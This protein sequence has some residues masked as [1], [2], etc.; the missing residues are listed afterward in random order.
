MNLNVPEF[1]IGLDLGQKVDFTAI[2]VLEFRPAAPPHFLLPWDVPRPS[3]ALRHLERMALGTTYTKVVERVAGL[4][5]IPELQRRCTL[6]VDATGVGAP[7]V[8][9]LRQK[10]LDCHLMPVTIT[11]GD[12]TGRHGEQRSVPK[13]DL[14]STVE[15]MLEEGE[16]RI[17]GRLPNR[18][19]LVEELM[20]LR[21][22]KTR[23]GQERFGASGRVH[24]DLVIAVSLACWAARRGSVGE[25]GQRLCW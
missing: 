3:Y 18:G 20:G 10:Q 22:G 9:A 7:V 21:V 1:Y 8:D 11:G 4:T 12:R 23:S 14:I 17:A 13:R 6:A 19:M 24:D 2:A 15:V 16:L 25:R 5:R